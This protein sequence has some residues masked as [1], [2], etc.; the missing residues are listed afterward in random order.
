VSSARDRIDAVPSLHD[1]LR[2]N[3]REVCRRFPGAYWRDLDARRAYPEEF[4]STLTRA[5]YLA[6]LIPEQYGGAGL[7]I[8]EAALI[9]EE[10]NK[11]GANALRAMRRCTSWRARASR[12]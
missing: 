10:I 1:S 12:L 3:V 8:T 2:Q 4:V 5:G 6:A 7:G 11:S 9:L